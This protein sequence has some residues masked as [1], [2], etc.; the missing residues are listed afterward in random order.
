MPQ[1]LL[2]QLMG[3]CT[4]T[5]IFIII[6]LV[7]LLQSRKD[8]TLGETGDKVIALFEK[9]SKDDEE[10]GHTKHRSYTNNTLK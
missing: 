5:V 9:V 8:C 7:K 10:A 1:L 4:K 3:L 2:A 6:E